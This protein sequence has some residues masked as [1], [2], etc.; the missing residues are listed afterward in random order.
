MRATTY[1]VPKPD[2]GRFCEPA[3]GYFQIVAKG[4]D[5]LFTRG[6]RRSQA[7]QALKDVAANKSAKPPT[8]ALFVY[9]L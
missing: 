2:Q 7:L 1:W 8:D 5:D 4:I 3:A 9:G 6:R